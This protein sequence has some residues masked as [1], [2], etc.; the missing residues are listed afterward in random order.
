[1]KIGNRKYIF[2]FILLIEVVSIFFLCNV[3]Y[4]RNGNKYNTFAFIIKNNNNIVENTLSKNWPNK[5][6]YKVESSCENIDGSVNNSSLIYES[7]TVTYKSSKSS[8]CSLKFSV[9]TTNPKV[10]IEHAGRGVISVKVDENESGVSKYCVS[11]DNNCIPNISI[12]KNEFNTSAVASNG[13]YYVRVEDKV[14]NIGTSS[15]ILLKV[16][17][18][19]YVF[20]GWFTTS[21]IVV[22]A[23]SKYGLNGTTADFKSCG[24][25][26]GEKAFENDNW[27]IYFL[28]SGN[29]TI[30]N[31]ASNVDIHAVG[32]GGGGANDNYGSGGAGGYTKYITNQKLNESKYTITIG[33]GGNKGV[34]GETSS[35]SLGTTI[36]LSANGG[37]YGASHTGYDNTWQ[38]CYSKN[39]PNSADGGSGGGAGTWGV[40]GKGGSNGGNGETTGFPHCGNFYSTMAGGKGQGT[41]TCDFGESSG[42]LR[43]GGGG[44][45]DDLKNSVGTGGNGGGGNGN[46]N[47]KNYYGGGG[48]GNGKTGGC[49]IV[50]IRSHR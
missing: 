42:V 7:N 50:I 45:Y 43:A 36:I 21:N 19:D 4:K 37:G 33:S 9:D 2:L 22:D 30:K 8:R 31:I 10:V 24:A 17:H 41:T 18:V 14:G 23:C 11:T 28:T 46:A 44:G 5:G 38:G 32:G 27:E 40:V 6:V 29:L 12:D 47:G 48:G 26:T 25:E 34:K 15:G 39:W 20:D 3:N 35:M 13:T 49:G 1:M 16:S